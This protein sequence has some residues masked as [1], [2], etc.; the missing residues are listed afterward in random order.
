MQ[1]YNYIAKDKNGE[2]QKGDIEAENEMAAAKVLASR[3]L[4]TISVFKEE[5]NGFDF[6]N[7]ISLKDKVIIARQLS[8]MINAGLP[9]AQSLKTLEEQVKKA[10]VKKMLEQVTS[11]IEG[12]SQLSVAF[13][14][15]PKVFTMID[16]TLIASGET[17]GTLDKALKRLADQLEQE[18]SLIRKVRGAMI[19]PI[20]LVVTV[21]VVVAA[22]MIYVMPQMESLY[23]S[24]NAQLPLL[25][26]ILIST[27]HFVSKFAPFLLILTIGGAIFIRFAINRPKG[28]RIWDST[29]LKIWGLN[30]LLIK[31]YMTRFARTLAGLVSSGVPLLDGL[32]ITSR[33]IGN[34]IYQELIMGAA[35]KVKS[36]IPLSEPLKES[37]LFPPVVPQMIAVGEKTGELDSMLENLADYFEEEVEVMVK[38]LSNLIEPIM[39]VVLGGLIGV[40]LLAIMMPIYSLGGV[41]FSK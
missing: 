12:G 11:D 2:I 28:R 30:Q 41:I 19:Y 17:G 38:N 22:M 26:R 4:I 36:G 27:S 1:S 32:T 3:E 34:V 29:K 10:N 15:F 13:S 8:T 7:R 23:G 5:G 40:I 6:L 9:I 39:I 35:E 25:T 20:F 37:L 31:V 21:I 18:Q 33:A 24:F 16:I 14:R